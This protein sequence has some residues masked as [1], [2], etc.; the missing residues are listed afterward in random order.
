MAVPHF[1]VDDEGNYF[2]VDMM[3]SFIEFFKPQVSKI[4]I[5]KLIN[6]LYITSWSDE[7]NN[8]EEDN[9]ISPMDVLKNPDR[10]PHHKKRI[11]NANLDYPLIIQ[12]QGE[13]FHIID[14]NHRFAK[15]YMQKATVVNCYIFTEKLMK[16]FFMFNVYI[17]SE[18]DY[19]HQ[20]ELEYLHMLFHKRFFG[21]LP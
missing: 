17:I 6:D 9:R 3:F 18:D 16:K 19:F 10:F 12:K 2:S 20:I 8:P 4:K 14:G 13:D 7:D 11:I 1:Y 21:K 15:L 5:D